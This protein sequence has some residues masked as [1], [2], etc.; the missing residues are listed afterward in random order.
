[1]KEALG[2]M[3]LTLSKTDHA[4]WARIVTALSE[5]LTALDMKSPDLID[6]EKLGPEAL[7]NLI[8]EPGDAGPIQL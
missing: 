2:L 7:K 8:D 4:P 3:R 1:V 6:A 5:Y